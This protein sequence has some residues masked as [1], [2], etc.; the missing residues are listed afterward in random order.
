[1][2]SKPEYGSVRHAGRARW[3]RARCC[4]AGHR[5]SIKYPGTKLQR[6]ETHRAV[7]LF[8]LSFD[9][10]ATAGFKLRVI[11]KREYLAT[12]KC[13]HFIVIMCWPLSIYGKRD[14]VYF[15]IH[16]FK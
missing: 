15:Y 10:H 5:C 12:M 6:G 8:E 3:G 2:I 14:N 16:L 1:M 13:L 7:S 4:C 9:L 11:V